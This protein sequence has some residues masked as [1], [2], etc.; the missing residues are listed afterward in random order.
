MYHRFRLGVGLIL[1]AGLSLALHAQDLDTV[2]NKNLAA[3]GGGDAL[4]QLK[5]LRVYGKIQ[6]PAMGMAFSYAVH[7]DNVRLEYAM[8]QHH[9]IMILTG[10]E[11]WQLNPMTGNREPMQIGAKE[12]TFLREMADIAGPLVDWRAKNHRIEP[13]GPVTVNGVA[14]FQLELF[15]HLGHHK[16]FYLDQQTG[17][18]WRIVEHHQGKQPVVKT[19]TAFQSV[20]GVTFPKEVEKRDTNLCHHETGHEAVK[21]C[22]G[23]YYVTFKTIETKPE[24]CRA[25]FRLKHKTSLLADAQ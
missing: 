10:K 16:T 25:L 21:H 2:I 9:I 20:D 18:V 8:G 14:T 12:T 19:T 7:E 4:R 15:T 6:G 5:S 3:R 23:L 11:G 1:L 24:L 13:V 17:L 22:P